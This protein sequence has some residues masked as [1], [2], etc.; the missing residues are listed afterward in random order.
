MSELQKRIKINLV[1][2]LR[3]IT[4]H[5]GLISQVEF[6]LFLHAR[7]FYEEEASLDFR[8]W[9]TSCSGYSLGKRIDDRALPRV[10]LA[11]Y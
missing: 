3:F 6:G 5:L 11:P 7:T 8:G 9:V 4:H 1:E 2:G 10:L